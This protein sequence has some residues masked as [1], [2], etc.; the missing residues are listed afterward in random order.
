MPTRRGG[1]FETREDEMRSAEPGGAYLWDDE[2]SGRV[3]QLM[4]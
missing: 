4:M 2:T 1:G 3:K